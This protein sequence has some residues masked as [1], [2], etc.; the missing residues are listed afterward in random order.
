[1]LAPASDEEMRQAAASAMALTVSPALTGS[2][3]A[4]VSSMNCVSS[5]CA[6]F[7]FARTS[8]GAAPE[9]RS[10]MASSTTGLLA[11]ATVMVW[12]SGWSPCKSLLVGAASG[13]VGAFWPT[14]SLAE[15]S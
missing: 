1:M 10:L 3:A 14:R 6:T 13:S 7:R 11:T 5:T 2:V 9:S 4:Y 15:A 12:V 8:S